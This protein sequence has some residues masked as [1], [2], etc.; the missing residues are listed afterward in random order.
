M[1]VAQGIR[2]VAETFIAKSFLSSVTE[3][4]T[5]VSV[6]KMEIEITIDRDFELYTEADQD[7]FLRAIREFLRMK[8]DLKVKKKRRGSVKITLELSLEQAEKLFRAIKLG[9]FERYGAV[10]AVVEPYSS[11]KPAWY[12]IQTRSR[13]E[14]VVRDQLAAKSIPQL[15]PLWR[16][17]SMWKDRVK[18][19][20]VPLFSG[21]LFG[22]FALQDRIAVLETIG[23]ARIVDINGKPVPIPD[24][25][26]AA[27]RTIMEHR[28]PCRPHPY[29]TQG[30][31]VQ[32]R[33]GVLAG[34]EGILIAKEERHCLVICID[35]IQQA[36]AVDIDIA[37][38]ERL[39]SPPTWNRWVS[40]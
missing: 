19:V 5:E 28:L 40:A 37:D 21:Y 35:I 7:R 6:D 3:S 31:W 24:E 38:V 10:D 25:Q 34:T 36:V 18:L 27:V 1:Q 32:V 4:V 8:S 9:H 29:L 26:I 39:E 23:V 14:K 16:R 11:L 12:A 15:L 33:H 30:M 20:D 13:H 2:A 22:Y 17:R